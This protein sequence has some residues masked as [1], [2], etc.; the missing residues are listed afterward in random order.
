MLRLDRN[1][2]KCVE[3]G[4]AGQ[5]ITK[6]ME[7]L[8]WRNNPAGGGSHLLVYKYSERRENTLISKQTVKHSCP[9]KQIT[10]ETV[11]VKQ[12]QVT[13]TPNWEELRKSS[14]S[15]PRS[16]FVASGSCLTQT[17]TRAGI[18]ASERGAAYSLTGLQI[19]IPLFSWHKKPLF[20][21]LMSC[22]ALLGASITHLYKYLPNQ[23]LMEEN[24]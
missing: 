17:R 8:S 14:E 16:I 13:F 1:I 10:R 18:A 15:T 5:M 19:Y 22:L 7:I 3:R 23:H 11:K 6:H 12:P 4:A 9:E 24:Q 20:L 21:Q 2:K